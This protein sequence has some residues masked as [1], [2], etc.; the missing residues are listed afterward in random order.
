MLAVSF[1]T[2]RKN[3]GAVIEKAAADHA[4]IRITRRGAEGVVLVAEA[5]WKP[6][7]ETLYQQPRTS[8]R[9]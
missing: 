5:D 8:D 1:S 9:S 4:A 6:I 3:L 7:H 2:A